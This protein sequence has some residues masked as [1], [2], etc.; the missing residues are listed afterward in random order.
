[1]LTCTRSLSLRAAYEFGPY[2]SDPLK[3]QAMSLVVPLNMVV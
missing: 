1:V 3:Y 2:V